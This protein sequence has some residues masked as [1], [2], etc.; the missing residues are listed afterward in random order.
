MAMRK[1]P[2]DDVSPT[3]NMVNVFIAMGVLSFQG[4]KSAT[5][6]GFYQYMDTPSGID[7]EPTTPT[8]WWP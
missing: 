5:T 1:P 2:F 6:H 4:C 8:G 7:D 3:I